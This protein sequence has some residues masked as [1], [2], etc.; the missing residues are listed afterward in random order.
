VDETPKR[1]YFDVFLQR[2][3]EGDGHKPLFIR[4][5][6]V[7]PNARERSARGHCL[8]ALVRIDDTP[9]ATMLRAAEPPSHTTWEHTT[10][11]FRDRYQHG[12]Q[13]IDFVV[14]APKFIADALSSAQQ[15]RDEFALAD[16]FPEPDDEGRDSLIQ[17]GKRKGTVT[18]PPPPPPPPP[19]PKPYRI[20]QT[21]EGFRVTRDNPASTALPA[22]LVIRVAYD[23]SRGNA[24]KKYHTADFTLKSLRPRITGASLIECEQNRLVV[25]PEADA[26]EIEINGFDP[27]RD[28][29]VRVAAEDALASEEDDA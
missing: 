20:A 13:T 23:T 17:R 3:M 4:A 10:G 11:T 16:F 6:L 15:E 21:P 9:L 22:S 1:S 24:L 26:F 8:L 18:K 5:G 28:L 12:R 7:V 14:G 29:L 2:D 19:R 25:V 27:K